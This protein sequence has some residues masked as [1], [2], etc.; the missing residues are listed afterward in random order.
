MWFPDRSAICFAIDLRDLRKI[1]PFFCGWI[2]RRFW[3]KTPNLRRRPVDTSRRELAPTQVDITEINTLNQQGVE[4]LQAT[5]RACAD[6]ERQAARLKQLV[7][8]FRLNR[9]H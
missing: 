2:F 5:L 9:S 7:G 8:S 6:L 3:R 1:S 4:N